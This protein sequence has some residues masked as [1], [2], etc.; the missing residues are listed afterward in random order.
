MQ[1]YRKKPVEVEAVKYDGK[2]TQDIMDWSE[3]AITEHP[4]NP[5]VLSMEAQGGTVTV[6]PGDYIIRG[7]EG[8][9]YPCK[10]SVFV[11]TYDAVEAE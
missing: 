6:E 9:F 8:E 4:G 10:A 3:G 11:A 7:V 2:N 1:K 5:Y